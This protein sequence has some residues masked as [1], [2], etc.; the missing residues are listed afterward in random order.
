MDEPQRTVSVFIEEEE[1]GSRELGK[2]LVYHAEIYDES[3][4]LISAVNSASLGRIGSFC[5]RGF[6]SQLLREEIG[7]RETDKITTIPAPYTV[8]SRVKAR[9]SREVE[10]RVRRPFTPEGLV[11]FRNWYFS[12]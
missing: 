10:T 9:T 4:V 11:E 7:L 5:E 1:D 8:P 3:G 6:A 12:H 2:D